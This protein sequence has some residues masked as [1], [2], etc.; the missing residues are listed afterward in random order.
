MF[1]LQPFWLLSLLGLAVPVA[2]HLWNRKKGRR[3]KVGSIALLRETQS[4]RMSNLRLTEAGLLLLRCLV[5][6]LLGLGLAGPRWN[7]LRPETQRAWVLVSPEL[8]EPLRDTTGLVRR[9]LDSL[10]GPARELRWFAEGFPP[11]SPGAGIGEAPAA[12]AGDY[13][14]LLRA[15]DAQLPGGTSVYLLTGERLAALRG[16]R[17]A[18]ALDLKWLTFPP[19]D[20]VGRAVRA[21]FLTPADSLRVVWRESRPEGNAMRTT[22]LPVATGAYPGPGGSTWRVSRTNGLPAVQ[23][24]DGPPVQADTATTRLVI[25][26]APAYRTDA[27]YVRAAAGAVARFTG[28]KMTVQTVMQPDGVPAAADWVFW[29]SHEP[30]PGGQPRSRTTFRYPRADPARDVSTP[31]RWPPATARPLRVYRRFTAATPGVPVWRDGYGQPVLTAE[32][33]EAGTVYHFSGRFDPQWNDLAWSEAFPEALLA[34]LDE[35]FSPAGRI[36]Q[37]QPSDRR[38]VDARQLLPRYAEREAARPERQH[39]VDLREPLLLAAALLFGLERLLSH[40]RRTQPLK[41]ATA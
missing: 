35:P 38:L 41:K 22:S 27:R 1:F 20:S 13:W 23:W 37:S 7:A 2:I 39:G 34:L 21:V 36:P 24:A 9:T 10:A 40:R 29:L 32:Q 31:L 12:P 6:A 28:R 11:V 14:D 16:E 3:I 17:P 26:H 25:Y 30:L 5:L 8:R 18:V 19:G 15:A 33:G 4:R